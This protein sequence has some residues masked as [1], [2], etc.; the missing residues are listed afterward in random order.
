MLPHENITALFTP[1]TIAVIGAS[2]TP[3]KVGHA[4]LSNLL[5]AGFSGTIFPVNP[6]GGT[7]RGLP[8][9]GKTGDIPAPLD[10]ALICLPAEK[11]AAALED[12]SRLPTR[13]AV[14]FSVGFKETGVAGALREDHVKN[15]A[16]K[17]NISLLGPNCLGFAHTASHINATYLEGALPSGGMGF[18]SQSR[19]LF[20]AGSD[21]A[22]SRKTGFSS[23]VSLGNKALIDES[24]VLAWMTGD[25]STRVIAGYLENVANGP[26]F[27]HCAHQATREKPVI[28]L[29]GGG[30]KEGKRASAAH[31]G[32]FSGKSRVYEAAFKQCGIIQAAR[33]EDLFHLSQAFAAQPL[34]KGP[35]L[36]VMTNAGGPGIVAVD[37]CENSGLTLSRFSMETLDALREFLPSYSAV[38]NP[39]DVIPDV[40]P[41]RFVRAANLLLDDAAVHALLI[42]IT[43]TLPGFPSLAAQALAKELR[44]QGK[45]VFACLLGGHSMDAGRGILTAAGIPC[46]EFPEQ[47]V[48]A[49]AA[50]HRFALWRERPLPVEIHYRHDLTKARGFIARARENGLPAIEGQEAQGLLKAFEMPL[51]ES[52]LAR[53]SAEAV[54]A[55]RQLGFPVCLELVTSGEGSRL[56]SAAHDLASV[57]EVREAFLELTGKTMRLFPESRISGCLVRLMPPKD[58]GAFAVTVSRDPV[59]GPVLSLSQSHSGHHVTSRIAPLC[60]DDVH[61]MVREAVAVLRREETPGAVPFSLTTLEDILLIM[62]R[63]ALEMPEVASAVCDPVYV[64]PDATLVA[65]AGFLLTPEPRHAPEPGRGE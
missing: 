48:D 34:P 44:S 62:S 13:A 54:Q 38:H 17:Y 42:L 7:I 30:S 20:A 50:M 58:A 49:A 65:R 37:A 8:V 56:E 39:V 57:E 61:D 11:V 53:T 1:G 6:K 52:V 35:G 63:L 43:P 29:R 55:A 51:L 4:V 41:E 2:A 31:S 60:L 5:E 40:T 22:R 12:L 14:V 19:G 46:Y 21:W 18:F 9:L 64:G 36:A 25:E 47:A 3:G 28:L 10:L 24:D 16:T 45:P 26:R 23:F 15:L 33:V 59:F 27:M 32:D